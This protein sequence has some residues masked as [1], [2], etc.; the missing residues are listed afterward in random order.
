MVTRIVATAENWTPVWLTT[1]EANNGAY[2]RNYSPVV[3]Q[4]PVILIQCSTTTDFWK[5]QAIG[6]V[7]QQVET[8]LLGG[9]LARA[10]AKRVLICDELSLIQFPFAVDYRIS[11][12]LFAKVAANFAL[13][14]YEYTG[15]I[16]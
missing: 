1:L 10:N 4:S 3:I 13:T 2:P 16:N 7:N 14:V 8:G 5:N 9:G 6:Y 11:I 12:D 15:V